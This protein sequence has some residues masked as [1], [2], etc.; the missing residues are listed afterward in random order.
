M[1]LSVGIVGL[2]NVGKSTL[3]NALLKKQIA[4]VSAYPFCTIEPNKGIVEVPDGR[5]SVLAEIV[6]TDRVVPAVV[7]FIDIAGLVKGAHKGE[8]L[9]NKFLA[10]IREVAVICHVIRFFQEDQVAHVSGRID[11]LSDVETV[12]SELILADLQTLE[13]QKKPKGKME[14]EE[15]IFW[16]GVERLKAKMDQ[17]VLARDVSLTEEER[18]AV[19]SLSLL[20]A[21]PVIYLANVAEDKLSQKVDFP[22]QPLISLS[23]KMESE[24]VVLSEE[25]QREY[26]SQYGLKEPGLNRLIRLAYDTLGLISFLTTTGGKEVRAWTVKKG[27]TAKEAA[28][29]VHTDFEKRFVK[30]D[31][32]SFEDFVQYQGWSNVR[33]LGKVRTEGRDYQVSDGDVIEF[34]AGR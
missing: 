29:V 25:E 8:G 34:K 14:K 23:A 1:S 19:S 10:H 24:I 26:L 32:I 12:N 33:S 27:T 6:G 13:K 30:A 17:G 5:L 18:A 4:D 2:P 7:E 28:G 11:P 9:G 22:Y 16:D 31:V 15:K 21:K 3:F 20:T